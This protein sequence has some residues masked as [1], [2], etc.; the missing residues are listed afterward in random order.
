MKKNNSNIILLN[1]E[2]KEITIH[3]NEKEWIITIEQS[4]DYCMFE[5]ISAVSAVSPETVIVF[6]F[7]I[8]LSYLTLQVQVKQQNI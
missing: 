1:N 3:Y 5:D 6:L 7:L 8:L 2:K 4:F